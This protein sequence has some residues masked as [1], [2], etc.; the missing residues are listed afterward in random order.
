MSEVNI[1]FDL[2]PAQMQVFRDPAR[3]RVLV[4]GRRFGKTHL[5]VA[6]A[7]CAALDPKNIKRQPVYLI[8]P[9]QPQAK[10]LYW[11]PLLDK[12]HPLIVHTNVNEGLITLNNGVMIGVKGADNPDALRG[13]GLWS[14]ILDEIGT[15]KAPTWEEIIRP[16][17]ADSKGRA[18][19]IGTPPL[20]RNHLYTMF[21]YGKNPDMREWKSWKFTTYDNPFIAPEEIAAMKGAMSTSVFR[22]EV[23]AEFV[24][25]GGGQI[26]EEWIKIDREEPKRGGYVVTVDLAG[27]AEV[28]KTA[29]AKQKQLDQTAIVAAKIVPGAALPTEKMKE[30]KEI[31]RYYDT[32]SWWIK[33][34]E[35]GRWGIK[36]TA[37]K[38]V[39]VLR[40][41]QPIAWGMERG[42]L[43]N[44]VLP[45]ID[46]E[47]MRQRVDLARPEPLSHENRIKN[48]RILWNLE[49]RFEHGKITFNEAPWNWEAIDQL[50]NFPAPM[51]HDDIPDAMAY[52]AQLAQGRVFE[53]FSEVEESPY[54]TPLD[55][56]IGF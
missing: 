30:G 40:I 39:D 20:G 23:L 38:I 24:T 5:A 7:G 11:R 51:V 35:F 13:V 10:I 53:D 36:D 52:I 3:F 33:N 16:A 46:E 27:F 21:E 18:L 14:A 49:G 31:A 56:D 50:V 55:S 22:R 45:L 54:W 37:R 44:A 19:F 1:Q 42:A 12:L 29:T 34:V 43:F 8:A 15:M 17:L 25:G 26:K 32:D 6:E 48:E 28:G 47:A 2:H 4:A 9:T 41:V